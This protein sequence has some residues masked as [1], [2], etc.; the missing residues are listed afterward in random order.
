[1]RCPMTNK[2]QGSTLLTSMIMLVV[3]T[4]LVVFSI[5]S[6]NTNL[7]IAGNA[8]SQGEANL[9]TQMAIEQVI[10]QVIGADDISLISAQSVT[11]PVGAATYTVAV[12][13]ITTCVVE[14]PVLN[15]SLDSENDNDR[16]CF[17]G[18]DDDKAIKADGTLT[19]KPS[20]CK[21]QQWEIEAGVTDG[22]TGAKVEHVQG[23]TIR[24]PST[25]TCL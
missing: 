16:A 5:R 4:L 7:L 22:V 14:V 9:A 23:V 24:V 13:A 17:A 8:Q 19:T 10:G 25:V 21:T 2:E 20:E 15:S 12:K 6:S 1:M 18:Q 3:L 11:V